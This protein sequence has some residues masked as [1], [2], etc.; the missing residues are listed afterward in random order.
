MQAPALS[1]FL[2]AAAAEK[3][4]LHLEE[5]RSEIQ[6]GIHAQESAQRLT[7][8]SRAY[9]LLLQ[10]SKGASNEVPLELLSLLY[11]YSKTAL[12]S[13]KIEEGYRKTARLLEFSFCMQLTLL[14]LANIEPYRW[15]N[16]ASLDQ[17]TA[18]FDVPEGCQG[19]F[20]CCFE[21]QT[22][23]AAVVAKAA[24]RLGIRRLVIDTI[25]LLSLAHQNIPALAAPSQQNSAF[26]EKWHT[27]IQLLELFT[28]ATYTCLL[29]VRNV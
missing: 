28:L 27:F 24:D 9:E 11:W 17:L 5:V 10:N 14:D 3:A 25:T 6:E 12:F 15:S 13:Q 18:S 4:P 1:L 29:F 8:F 26:H 16:F 23:A 2:A 21:V 20:F 22:V 19:N 7:H